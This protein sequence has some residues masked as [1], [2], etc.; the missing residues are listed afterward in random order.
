MTPHVHDKE[1][2]TVPGASADVGVPDR[3]VP[4]RKGEV[5][6]FLG[7]ALAA[8]AGALF[9]VR[10]EFYAAGVHVLA[11]QAAALVH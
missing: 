2:G 11:T 9:V 3:D 5:R 4:P 10:P 7:L 1:P 6:E 8:G